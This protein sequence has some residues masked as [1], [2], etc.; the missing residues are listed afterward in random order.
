MTNLGGTDKA[1]AQLKGLAA[2]FD[3]YAKVFQAAEKQVT[4]Y[5]LGLQFDKQDV[6]R[7]VSRTSLVPGGAWARFLAL[8]PPAKEN[9]LAGLPA[10]PFVVAGGGV[11]SDA[12]LEAMTR[13]S[14]D[15]MKSM[16]GLYGLS[17]SQ[18]EK[19]KTLRRQAMKQCRV[20]SMILGVGAGHEPIFAGGLGVMRVDRA[21]AFMADYEEDFKQNA[22]FF[23]SVNSP[24]LPR[25]DVEK[26]EVAGL[27]ALK[28]TTTIPSFPQGQQ[29]PQV[30]KMREAYIGPGEKML[31]WMA[32]ADEHQVLLGYVSKE[33]LQR[34]VEAIQKGEP[35]LAHDAAVA[36]TAALLPAG[37]STVAFL[38]PA[39]AIDFIQRIVP[40]L[41]PPQ[42][43]IDWKLP[44]FGATPPIGFAATA[45]P[46]ELRT[47]LV[48]PAEV[49]QAISQY[50][51]KVRAMRSTSVK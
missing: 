5:G 38:S 29:P 39:G 49:L 1:A 41:M 8:V 28:I 7:V 36:K 33:P 17:E 6:L 9:L 10:G 12:M 37:A 48:V 18:I 15:L 40:E 43:K 26:S 23:K 31:A 35:G 20:L 13:W 45:A 50:V 42:A 51:R 24:M 16:R 27:P 25:P 32:P 2:V 11:L 44:A 30:A 14:I 47:C 22:A 3:V 4:A 46:E 21:K 34:A 19:M